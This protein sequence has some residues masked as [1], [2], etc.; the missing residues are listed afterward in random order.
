MDSTRQP[1]NCYCISGCGFMSPVCFCVF[2]CVC[3]C[4]RVC[5]CECARAEAGCTDLTGLLVRETLRD[6]RQLS[7]LS[8]V[9]PERSS[10]TYSWDDSVLSCL[11]FLRPPCEPKTRR[12]TVR[13]MKTYHSSPKGGRGEFNSTLWLPPQHTKPG[14]GNVFCSLRWFKVVPHITKPCKMDQMDEMD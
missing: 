5:V 12:A 2:V 6:S 14:V 13:L 11:L 1:H 7:S 4:A 3:A 10:W 8:S 9:M